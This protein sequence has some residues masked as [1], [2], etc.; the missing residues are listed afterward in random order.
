MMVTDKSIIIIRLMLARQ[1]DYYCLLLGITPT[2]VLCTLVLS[3]HSHGRQL[4]HIRRSKHCCWS[5]P[6]R[7][8]EN[9]N[10]NSYD[11]EEILVTW[12]TR[13]CVLQGMGLKVVSL[14]NLITCAQMGCHC[15]TESLKHYLCIL[16]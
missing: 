15:A 1:H 3:W 9:C 11:Y 10:F 12:H 14:T 5:T 13:V 16:H 7:F 6:Y 4:L 2:T 8:T